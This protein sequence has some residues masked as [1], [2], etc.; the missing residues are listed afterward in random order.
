MQ[1]STRSIST[2]VKHFFSGTMISRCTGLAREVA[3]AA[4]FGT[5]PAVAAF[6]MAFRFAH[7]L[8]RLFGEG[9]LH[10]VF[11]PHFESLRKRKSELA[12]RF[13]YDLS[14][15]VALFLILIIAIVEGILGGILLFS[16]MSEDNK[17]ILRLT[18][19]MMPA[20]VFISL[21]ALNT[22]LL[23]CERS[24][25]LPSVAPSA[26]NLLWVL[27]I[28]LVWQK[29]V[30]RAIEYLAMIIVLAFALQWAVTVPKVFQYLSKELGDKWG[31][32]RFA[33]REMLQIMRPFALG[34]IGVA[35]TQINS[36][37][38]AVF[39]RMADPQGPAYLWYALRIQQLPLAVI[40]VG[41]TGALL[42]PIARAVQRQETKQYLHFLNFALKR[43]ILWMLP[44]TAALFVLGFSGINLVY[45]HGKFCQD[46]IIETTFCLWAYGSALIPM[47]FVL[48]L[49]SAFYAHKNYRIPTLLSLFTVALNILL[50]TLF[51]F[52]FHLGVISIA[53][54]TTLST[55]LNS[56]L[57]AFFLKKKYGLVLEGVILSSIKVL[58]VCIVATAITLFFGLYLFHDNTFQWI[59]QHELTVFPRE[60]FTQLI[61]FC[62][63]AL[64]FSVTFIAGAYLLRIDEILVFLPW[65]RERDGCKTNQQ[66]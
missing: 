19:V 42:P 50:N 49:A 62:V 32:N 14:T 44:T 18:M 9:A 46:S 63:Q 5:V 43:A 3:M 57:L 37:L 36:A 24:F 27:A 52:I 8:R 34:V 33:G 66:A 17:E 41:L 51:V 1:D 53:L 7:L 15:G 29:P 35:A 10:A 30:S 47:I 61:S 20:L 48:I 12:A 26:L 45:G 39:A 65:L 59:I 2:G 40:G 11:V 28:F 13:F 22:S 4:V 23:N 64:C 21:Y 54:A 58:L 56:G 38:D 25:F 55:C 6:W 16:Q 60:L 31:E